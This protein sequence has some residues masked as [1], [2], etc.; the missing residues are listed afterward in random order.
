M[1]AALVHERCVDRQRRSP[2]ARAVRAHP[3]T[4]RLE[5]F[6]D[7][8]GRDAAARLHGRIE[9]GDPV[10]IILDAALDASLIVMGAHRGGDMDEIFIGD[11][12]DFVVSDAPCPVITLR[13]TAE[14]GTI[15]DKRREER[16]SI[17]A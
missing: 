1:A 3:G 12:A 11:V 10:R 5:E 9:S 6:I 16:I 14:K 7:G 15:D 8:F 2:H 4:R 17:D 13:E